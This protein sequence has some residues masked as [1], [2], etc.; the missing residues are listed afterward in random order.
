MTS[1]QT[2]TMEFVGASEMWHLGKQQPIPTRVQK[3]VGGSIVSK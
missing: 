3:E 1:T 2:A